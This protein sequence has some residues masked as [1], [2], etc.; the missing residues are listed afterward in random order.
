MLF[1]GK[2]IFAGCTK[3]ALPGQTK[4]AILKQSESYMK[5]LYSGGFAKDF[6]KREKRRWAAF[7]GVLWYIK[8]RIVGDVSKTEE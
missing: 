8:R 4:R 2:L 5:V 1:A 6:R 7:E 3:K